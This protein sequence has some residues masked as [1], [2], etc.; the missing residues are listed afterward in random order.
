MRR[1]SDQDFG[2]TLVE[3][4]IACAIAVS[5]AATM[6][7]VALGSIDRGQARQAVR[8]LVAECARARGEALARSVAVAIGFG[9]E[10][11]GSPMSLHADGNG[12]GVR[13]AEI[14]SGTDPLLSAPRRLADLF[15]GVRIGTVDPAAGGTAVRLG[16]TRLLTFSPLGTSTS[17]SIYV[18]G[19]DG[20]QYA[21][22]IA[23]SAARVR[24]LRLNRS[25]GVWNQL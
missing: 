13:S 5:L 17:G 3:V 22:R 25:T 8:Y 23:G 10:S 4:L 18:T 21:L 14:I 1:R 19:R 12:N 20:S 9:P 2:F 6:G 11:E 7:G 15:P 16:G 24:L